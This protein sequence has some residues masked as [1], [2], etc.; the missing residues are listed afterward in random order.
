MIDFHLDAFAFQNHI[1]SDPQNLGAVE[2]EITPKSD[3]IQLWQEFQAGNETAYATIYRN[4]VS[5]LY[6]YGQKLINDKE[7]VK[8]CIQDLFVEIWNNKHKLAKVKSIKSYLLKSIRRKLIAE[9]IKRRKTYSDSPL[10]SYLKLHT[11]PSAELKLIEKQQFDAQQRKLKK[12]MN[13]LT[14]RQREAVHLK[15]YFQLS[16][17]EIAEVMALSTKGAYKLMGRSIHFLRKHMA[18]TFLG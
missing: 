9:S 5:L 17:A 15:Y 11:N 7:L 6:G 8:D 12:G 3:D 2:L 4:N 14:D 16:Y 10:S 1:S 18:D 13:N